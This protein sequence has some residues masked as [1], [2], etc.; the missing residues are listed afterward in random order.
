VEKSIWIEPKAENDAPMAE[1]FE[2]TF[3]ILTH[4]VAHNPYSTPPI[5]IN[6]TGGIP[7]DYNLLHGIAPDLENN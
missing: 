1:A 2:K 4:W 7:N 6:I 5:V 3:E